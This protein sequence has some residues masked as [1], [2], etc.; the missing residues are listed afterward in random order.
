MRTIVI[1]TILTCVVSLSPPTKND[2]AAYIH[3]SNI[4]AAAAKPVSSGI[5]SH[6][7]HYIST[8]AKWGP[9]LAGAGIGM[10]VG[11]AVATGGYFLVS[12]IIGPYVGTGIGTWIGHKIS[13]VTHAVSGIAN[14]ALKS[15]TSVFFGDTFSEFRIAKDGLQALHEALNATR[16]DPGL[17]QS[18]NKVDTYL[19]GIRFEKPTEY[20][21]GLKTIYAPAAANFRLFWETE[22]KVCTVLAGG[23]SMAETVGELGDKIEALTPWGMNYAVRLAKIFSVTVISSAGALSSLLE[24]KSEVEILLSYL[25]TARSNIASLEAKDATLRSNQGFLR[26]K[27]GSLV[28]GAKRMLRL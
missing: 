26:H 4:L 13:G 7:S 22:E 23:K 3:Y 15:M 2:E 16:K 10:S 27:L 28:R 21:N 8:L 19:D 9:I 11:S 18:V 20:I 14:A 12:W 1:A 25:E 5:S 6:F 17:M 24:G